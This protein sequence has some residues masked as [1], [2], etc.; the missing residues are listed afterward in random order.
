MKF[1]T[2]R[3]AGTLGVG[4]LEAGT[5]SFRPLAGL[6]VDQGG[7]TCLVENWADLA[8]GLTAR[9]GQ[10]VSLDSV[11]VLAPIPRPRRNVI[12]V[13]KNYS[14]HVKEFEQSGYDQTASK[15][16]L[17]KPAFF[18]KATTS[19]V[20]PNSIIGDQSAVTTEVDYEAE[21]AVI[22]GQ[23]CRNVSTRDA[24]DYVWG[25]T[26]V[27]DITARDLQRDH[28]QWFFGKGL[29][30]FC[31][32]GPVAVTKDEVDLQDAWITTHVNGELR[33]TSNINQLL[34]DV[35][36]LIAILSTGITLEPGD[37]IATG[38][39]SGVGVG[40]TPPRFLNAGD[41]VSVRIQGLGC[42]TNQYGGSDFTEQ[43]LLAEG[44]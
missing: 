18:T 37:V 2:Y 31:P 21:F 30:G 27:N 20:A 29:D 23:A 35:P 24:L 33:Q 16:S 22:I 6:P 34:R 42:L 28:Q 12:C 38:T 9:A 14:D 25:Y 40:F 8:D 15:D 11:E 10:P 5:G 41:V 7:V 4:L 1:I 13:G 26:I 3:Q 32:M 19:V 17:D 44:L 36:E 43:T 39:P